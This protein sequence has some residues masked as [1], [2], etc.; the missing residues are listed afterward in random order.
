MKAKKFKHVQ[1]GDIAVDANCFG[2]LGTVI[3]KGLFKEGIKT[4][5]S[6]YSKSEYKEWFTKKELKTLEMVTVRDKF[7]DFLMVYDFDPSS[8]VVLKAEPINTNKKIIVKPTKTIPKQ[9]NELALSTV[10]LQELSNIIFEIEL[11][12]GNTISPEVIEASTKMRF[13]FLEYLTKKFVDAEIFISVKKEYDIMGH[14][15]TY[16]DNSF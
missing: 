6:F 9:K 8:A 1:I 4:Q 3:W 15:N 5:P 7:E 2:E 14:L 13:D 10:I 12:K 11:A 16:P